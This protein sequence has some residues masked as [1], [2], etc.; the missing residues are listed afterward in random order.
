MQRLDEDDDEDDARPLAESLL[1][2]VA[3]LLFCPD[4]TAQSHKK[5]GQVSPSTRSVSHSAP[6]LRHLPALSVS[7]RRHQASE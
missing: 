5:N 6:A 3:D 4:F 7:L 2:A 1:L